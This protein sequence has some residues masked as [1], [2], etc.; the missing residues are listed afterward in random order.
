[1]VMLHQNSAEVQMLAKALGGRVQED[2]R[3]LRNIYVDGIQVWPDPGLQPADVGSTVTPGTTLSSE[4]MRISPAVLSALLQNAGAQTSLP[5]GTAD[6]IVDK[7]TDA[8]A[9]SGQVLYDVLKDNTV[10]GS[11]IINPSTLDSYYRDN[12]SVGDQTLQILTGP[13]R[14]LQQTRGFD[15]D[16]E[17]YL[18]ENLPPELHGILPA[19]WDTANTYTI[20]LNTGGITLNVRPLTGRWRRARDVDG[21]PAGLII[22]WDRLGHGT[23][24]ATTA[25]GPGLRRHGNIIGTIFGSPLPDW[26][27]SLLDSNNVSKSV[28]VDADMLAIRDSADGNRW[29]LVRYEHGRGLQGNPGPRGMRG[30]IGRPGRDSTVRGPRGLPGR[31]SMV[32]G[33]PGQ[34]GWYPSGYEIITPSGDSEA[35]QL[36]ITQW[37]RAPAGMPSPL[38]IAGN[39]RGPKGDMGDTVTGPAGEPGEPGADGDLVSVTVASGSGIAISYSRPNRTLVIDSS[40]LAERVRALENA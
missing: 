26:Y 19:V 17:V 34:A 13:S 31:D 2:G 10:F 28:P 5:L 36:R 1:M 3:T 20:D 39:L 23:E 29:K 7:N 14:W 37:T 25:F 30:P 8:R 9:W 16:P 6:N 24:A 4:G 12:A 38:T 35:R 32:P 18:R 15:G 21:L 27:L 11:R 33:P 22:L 40:A